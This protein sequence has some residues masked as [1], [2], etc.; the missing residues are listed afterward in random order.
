MNRIN[1]YKSFYLVI[2]LILLILIFFGAFNI[3]ENEAL[4]LN[5][6]EDTAGWINFYHINSCDYSFFDIL[7]SYELNYDI[8]IRYE[9]SGS[10]ECFGKNFWIDYIPE[11]RIEDGWKQFSSRKFVIRI[12]TNLHLDLILQTIIWLVLVSFIPKLQNSLTKKNVLPVFFGVLLMY[13]HYLGESKYYSTIGRDYYPY[14]MYRDYDNSFSFDNYFLYTYLLIF[15]YIF[16]TLNKILST[17]MQNV[18]N[19]FPF[20]FLIYG[21]YT[22][23]NLNFFFIVLSFIGIISLFKV[24]INLKFLLLYLLFFIF[25]FTN[26]ENLSINF[27]VDKLKGFVNSSQ[28]NISLFYWGISF[29]LLLIGINYL[30][31]VSKNYINFNLITTN[32]LTSSSLLVLLG[33]IGATNLPINFLSFYMLGHNKNGMTTLLSVEGN[34]WR[35]IFPSA[36]AVGEFYGFVILF[37]LIVTLSGQ[38]KF[39]IYHIVLLLI[40]FYG[41]YRANNASAT[42]TV[43]IFVFIA[44]VHHKIKNKKIR[45]SVYFGLIL[46]TILGI[47]FLIFNSSFGLL[48]GSVMFESV[49][50][51]EINYDFTLNEYNQSAVD[52]ANYG[53]LLSLPSDDTNFSNSLTYLLNSYTYGNKIDNLPS[54]LSLVSSVAYLINRSE[55]W[56]IFVAKYNPTIL[57]FLFGYGPNQLAEYYLGHE[58]KYQDGLVLPHSTFL[59]FLI[60]FGVLGSL[61]LFLLIFYYLFKNKENF[62]LNILVI[63]FL[64][65]F[66]KSD[67]A[68]YFSTFLTFLTIFNFLKHKILVR[69]INNE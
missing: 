37:T 8:S 9:P 66:I 33:V 51:S 61:G 43:L 3:S 65:N 5:L 18:I 23:L 12:A 64:I 54:A 52:E 28:S 59:S 29:Y 46:I 41:F 67:S 63:Y 39:K 55:K 1:S 24:K 25:W 30:I 34:A 48:S 62:Y 10:I 45:M 14:L 53:L 60:F 32:L 11:K 40:N 42:I 47:L 49:K 19:Y 36:E 17:R 56:G 31:T 35:G 44:L 68:L 7:S 27:D 22:S 50:A 20:I 38:Y 2:L 15:F 16:Y 6:E 58:T 26:S 21:T 4:T 13:L 57:E 69:K